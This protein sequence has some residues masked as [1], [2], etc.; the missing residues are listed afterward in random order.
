MAR[1]KDCPELL[2]LWQESSENGKDVLRETLRMVEQGILEE[3]IRAYL[4]AAPYERTEAR[5]AG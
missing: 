4:C 2:A 3:E 5:K 1:K